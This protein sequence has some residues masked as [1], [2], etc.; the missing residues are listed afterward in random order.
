MRVRNRN[1]KI[2]G[3]IGF[4]LICLAIFVY[5]Y[6]L[7]GGR[8]PLED[9]FTARVMLPTAF[10]LA[11]N[12]DVR[13]AGVKVGT[14]TDV[15]SRG[16]AGLVT[17]DLDEDVL[18][19]YRDAIVRLRTKTLVGENYL[20]LQPGSP[21]AGE[22][23]ENG[24]LP[25]EQAGEAVQLDKILSTLDPRTRSM[26]K[27][28]LDELGPGLAG[29]GESLNRIY[30]ALSPVTRDGGAVMR[31]LSRQRAQVASVVDETGE[32]MHAFGDRS[33][34]LRTLVTEMKRTSE[35]AGSRDAQLAAAIRELPGALT[36]ARGTA[37]R[38]GAFASRALPATADLSRATEQ[39]P[40]AMGD[41][42]RAAARTRPLLRALPGSLDRLD[43]L[44]AKLRPLSDALRPTLHSADELLRQA[45]PM[46]RYIEPYSRELGAFFSHAGSWANGTDATDNVGRV[47]ISV[48]PQTLAMMRPEVRDAVNG[49]LDATG[50]SKLYRPRENPYPKADSMNSPQPFD[51][52]YPSIEA[53]PLPGG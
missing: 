15:E 11:K 3:V 22:L 30:G 23:P 10:T 28:T 34:Q 2:A 8:S 41:L 45:N 53:D 29:R 37:T 26:V 19:V 31:V 40:G 43:P 49:L 17:F 50:I 51:G 33:A 36:Q 9:R 16:A 27:R 6:T 52:S 1:A 20:D 46:L 18:P 5:M 38:L 21:R 39:L 13:S 4:T 25:L 7:A 14:V 44:T 42:D 48:G 12:G 32:L 35:A 24:T 47:H